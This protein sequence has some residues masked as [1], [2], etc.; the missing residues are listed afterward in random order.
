MRPQHRL[1]TEVL[2]ISVAL[3]ALGSLLLSAAPLGAQCPLTC[4]SQVNLSLGPDGTALF[5][6]SNGLAS[7]PGACS[8]EY[9]VSLFD[10]NQM[11]ISNPV[12]CDRL[13]KNLFFHVTYLPQGNYCWGR[14]LIEDKLAPEILC[15][16]DTVLCNEPSGPSHAG[17]VSAI[18]NCDQDPDIHLVTETIRDLDCNRPD[19]HIREIERQWAATDASGNLSPPCTQVIRIRRATLNDIIFPN[20]RTG[21]NAI[22]CETPD[23]GPA[24]TGEPTVFGGTNDV[25]CKVVFSHMDDTLS[26]C[27]GSFSVQRT[28]TAIDCCT[29]ATTSHLQIISVSDRQAPTLVC[30]PSI[31]VSTKTTSCTADITLLPAIASDNCSGDPTISVVTSWGGSGLGPF[32]DVPEGGYKAHYIGVDPC[33]NRDTCSIDIM[34]KDLVPPTALCR[35]PVTAYLDGQGKDT[36]TVSEVNAGSTDNCSMSMGQIKFMGEPDSL[37]RDSL[38]VGCQDMDSDLMIILRVMDCFNNAGS[39]MTP[40]IV[41]DTLAPVLDCPTDTELECVVFSDYPDFGGTPTVEDNCSGTELVFSDSINLNDCQVG[42]ILRTWSAKDNFNNAV[43]CTQ[44]IGL[45][46]NTLPEIIWPKDTILPCSKTVDPLDAGLPLVTDNCALLAV[47]YTDSV[48]MVANACDTIFRTWRVK[49]WCSDF[50]SAFTQ[51]IDLFDDSPP[52]F[53]DC[54][55]DMEYILDGACTYFVQLDS[56]QILEECGHYLLVTNDSPHAFEK[57]GNASGIYPPGEY[58]IQFRAAD[59][60]NADTCTTLIVVKDVT[61]PYLVCK[62]LTDTIGADSLYL[63][64]P[65]DMVEIASD[66]CSPVTLTA[67]DTLFDCNDILKQLAIVITATDT[68]GNMATCVDTLFLL[69]NGACGP[70]VP[71]DWVPISG[72]VAD[73]LGNPIAEIPLAFD[74]GPY[75]EW[76]KTDSDGRFS[77]QPYPPGVSLNVQAHTQFIDLE[78]ITTADVVAI[79]SHLSGKT[80]FTEPLVHLAADVNRS[81]HITVADVI[82]L[83]KAII[84][85]DPS[86]GAGFWRFTSNQLPDSLGSG[87]IDE[88]FWSGAQTIDDL[89]QLQPAVDFIG[90]RT[91]DVNFSWMEKKNHG[92]GHYR[93]LNVGMPATAK[94]GETIIISLTAAESVRMNG[95]QFAL[96]FDPEKVRF[97]SMDSDGV[98]GLAPENFHEV[99]AGKVRIQWDNLENKLSHAGDLLL[100]LRFEVMQDV[101][102]PDWLWLDRQDIAPEVSLDNAQ[103]ADVQLQW[104]IRDSIRLG[105]LVLYPPHPNPFVRETRI[106]FDLA[107]ES[108]AQI[109]VFDLKG[110]ILYEVR[111]TLHAGRHTIPLDEVIFPGT[112]V[113]QFQVRTDKTVGHCAISCIKE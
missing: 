67:S 103:H 101:S 77:S 1:R 18:D 80:P 21:A 99:N 92:S 36:I 32:L 100:A 79:S 57:G 110:T 89:N 4:L 40:L 35:F 15:L 61:P 22:S 86:F 27:E 94:A 17:S 70:L 9:T 14:V 8:A 98:D 28:W 55:D 52:T 109:T 62:P 30:P 10:E 26:V 97:V 29:N 108:A 13:G 82:A 5:T 105:G 69:N 91:G 72:K 58:F 20:D 49:D 33:G 59:A 2:R 81:G 87:E 37:F 31:F 90:I 111:G 43:S 83:R 73:P 50:D 64:N 16:G 84:R 56:V 60:C 53:T 47:G 78:G 51:R 7:L 3:Y 112:G 95:L 23:I 113:Y 39:C 96:G 106:S 38:V 107:E 104:P 85:Q 88:E 11:P 65:W 42:F 76:R 63:L 34:I 6:P 25:L 66:L 12:D 54:P 41:K 71:G 24:V 45:V 19:L 102:A 48:I 93:T 68:F 74:F 46:D 75:R 44:L